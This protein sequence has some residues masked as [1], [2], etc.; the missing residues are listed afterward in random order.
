MKLPPVLLTLEDTLVVELHSEQILGLALGHIINDIFIVEQI[1]LVHL[2]GDSFA[3]R[4][5]DTVQEFGGFWIR[6]SPTQTLG[7]VFAW[8]KLLDVISVI[9]FVHVAQSHVAE[10]QQTRVVGSGGA[11]VVGRFGHHVSKVDALAKHVSG[12]RSL[13]RSNA[14]TLGQ[15]ASK[16]GGPGTMPQE[17][18]VAKGLKLGESLLLS[19]SFNL[20]NVLN[21]QFIQVVSGGVGVLDIFGQDLELVRLLVQDTHVGLEFDVVG[22]DGVDIVVFILALQQVV[23]NLN[24]QQIVKHVNLGL[25]GMAST[26]LSCKLS[27]ISYLDDV[28]I[29]QDRWRLHSKVMRDQGE[30]SVGCIQKLGLVGVAR[31]D[32]V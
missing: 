6:F 18:P 20:E 19:L 11:A 24:L 12:D 16:V 5:L 4:H 2:G 30:K 1:G 9:P 29:V 22:V 13:W 17:H 31:S 15:N 28:R 3:H 7:A 27:V 8:R 10:E 23:G 26:N 32:Q 25:K 14:K 21:F